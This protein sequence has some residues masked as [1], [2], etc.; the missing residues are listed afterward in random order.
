MGFPLLLG[1]SQI[2]GF[3]QQ[4]QAFYNRVAG[5]Y[6]GAIRLVARLAGGG[7]GKPS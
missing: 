4:Y 5:L 1:E 7:G 3:N 6:D 2:S